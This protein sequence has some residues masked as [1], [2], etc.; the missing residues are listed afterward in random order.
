VNIFSKNISGEVD[1]MRLRLIIAFL[2][3]VFVTI[4]I[5]I[6]V[7]LH[8]TTQEVRNFLSRGG[9]T[10]SEDVVLALVEH[11]EV[12]GTWE[13]VSHVLR[14]ASRLPRGMMWGQR[15]KPKQTTR[16]EIPP[17][18]LRLV[19]TDGHLIAHSREAKIVAD[20]RLTQVEIQRGVPLVI[21]GET[22]GYLVPDTAQFFSTANEISLLTRLNRAAIIAVGIAGLVAILLALLLSYSLVRPVRALTTAASNLA[23]GDLTHRVQVD[24]SDELAT[25]GRTFN[26]MAE[27]LQ[28][29]ATSRRAMTADIAH[30]LRTPLAVQRAH[31]EAIEDG[32]YPLSR[33]NLGTIEEQNQLLTRLVEDLQTLAMVDA[34]R[35]DLQTTST[36]FPDLVKRVARRFEPQAGESGIEIQ[37]SLDENCPQIKVDSQRVQQIL[38]NLFSNAIRYSPDDEQIT[39][40][41]TCHPEEVALSLRD[42]GPGI[43]DNVLPHIFER[44]YRGDKSRSRSE[45]GTGLGLSI[46]RK[47]AQAHGGDLAVV[48]HADGGAIFTLTL[49]VA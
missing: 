29:A 37:L 31:L 15:T 18:N 20:E 2:L 42:R 14:N 49:P 40:T 10:G 45:G 46:A 24:G 7:T 9:L 33:E 25:L 47:L 39:L 3:I 16:M 48:N 19:D 35:L 13:D 34:G 43:P 32:V 6:G 44:F 4:G 36:N 28:I 26:Q 5:F 8:Q 21:N 1:L 30:E 12:H 41:L 38:H 22:V 17:P 11:Y 23:T 27:S